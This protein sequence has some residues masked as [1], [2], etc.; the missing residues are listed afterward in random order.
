MRLKI[1]ALSTSLTI[2]VL[3]SSILISGC[4]E[5]KPPQQI[6]RYFWD[7]IEAKD[8]DTA[9][10][11]ATVASQDRIDLLEE[12]FKVTEVTFGKILIDGDTTTIETTIQILKSGS[13]ETMPLQTVLVKEMGLWKVDYMQ[14][15]STF[16]IHF[17]L[18]EM[19][20]AMQ[21]FGNR[22]TE[23]IDKSLDDLKDKMPEIEKKI[24]ELSA[25]ASER[26][27]EAWEQFLPEIEKKV[28]EF[29]KAL[30]RALKNGSAG[31]DDAPVQKNQHS[32]DSITF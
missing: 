21:L 27:R 18:A 24:N 3:L 13:D 25:T 31:H 17:S 22:F 2:F 16:S 19:L 12:R 32:D 7:A 20:N 9:H 23:G 14:T 15:K 1:S 6:A 4:L 8:T 29:G 10:K 11:Y 30:E 26:I 5:S 28:E